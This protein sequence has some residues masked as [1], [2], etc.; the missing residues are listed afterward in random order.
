M[1]HVVDEALKRAR[2]G[3]GPTLIEAL[4]YRLSDH[5]TADDASRY[6][7][8]AAVEAAWSK[9]PIVRLRAFLTEAGVW[10]E[11]KEQDLAASVEEEI[12]TAV[13]RYLAMP[14]EPPEA[15]FDHL[16][17]ALPPSLLKQRQMA[18]A[19]AEEGVSDG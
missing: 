2:D 5:T 17:A 12:E 14:A 19:N 18:Q 11:A 7:D 8:P 13:E 16:F 10:D 4:T 15:M 3:G 6:R 1:R 9:E